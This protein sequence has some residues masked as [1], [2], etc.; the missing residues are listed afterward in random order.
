MLRNTFIVVTAVCCLAG[1]CSNKLSFSTTDRPLS[2]A[3]HLRGTEAKAPPAR[4]RA[5]G[6]KPGA[7]PSRA[8]PLR[9]VPPQLVPRSASRPILHLIESDVGSDSSVV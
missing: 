2:E 7:V 1:G 3:A 8:A 6:Q 4:T 9:A 5:A